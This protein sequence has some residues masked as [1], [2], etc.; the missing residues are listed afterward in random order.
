MQLQSTTMRM[1]TNQATDA[2]PETN[3]APKNVWF[4]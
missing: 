3:I 4:Q 2:L 1:S